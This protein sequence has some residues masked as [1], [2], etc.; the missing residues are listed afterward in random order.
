MSRVGGDDICMI[1][2]AICN[3]TNF[4]SP[5]SYK[6]ER[7]GVLTFHCTRSILHCTL[8][9]ER[10][11]LVVTQHILS[12]K[13]LM[14]ADSDF[15]TPPPRAALT[16]FSMPTGHPDWRLATSSMYPQKVYTSGRHRSTIRRILL[17][18]D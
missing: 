16:A 4:S 15:A 5:R 10:P 3:R 6:L 8:M 18:L 14:K 17:A 11:T 9:R 1:E 2:K 13:G 12:W 7:Y